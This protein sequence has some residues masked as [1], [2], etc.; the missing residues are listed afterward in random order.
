MAGLA[1]LDL[2]QPEDDQA[3]C[4]HYS[5]YRLLKLG[6]NR[7]ETI[8]YLKSRIGYTELPFGVKLGQPP[9][10]LAQRLRGLG[11]EVGEQGNAPVDRIKDLLWAGIPVILLINAAVEVRISTEPRLHYWV[12][13][14]YD[15]SY[16]YVLDPGS[17]DQFRITWYDLSILRYFKGKTAGLYSVDNVPGYGPTGKIA[18]RMLDLAPIDDAIYWTTVDTLERS[19]GANRG[20][21][22][23]FDRPLPSARVI[24][25]GVRPE[26]PSVISNPGAAAGVVSQLLVRKSSVPATLSANQHGLT[27]NWFQATTG[28]QGLQLEIYEDASGPGIGYVQGAWFTFDYA[29]SGGP[30]RQRWYT[31][32][33]R[34][35]ATGPPAELTLYAN[36]NGNF[37]APP[38][39]SAEVVGSVQLSFRDCNNGSFSYSFT[40]GS[41]RKGTLAITRLLKNV[42]CTVSGAPPSASSKEFAYSG[43]WYDASTSGQGIVVELN[44]AQGYAFVGWFTYAPA[45]TGQ[46]SGLAGQRWYTAQGKYTVGATTVPLTLHEVTGG[47]FDSPSPTPSFK[48]VGSATLS[49]VDCGHASF[50]YSF[51]GGSSSGMSR[52]ID[53]VRVGPT[54]KGCI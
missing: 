24:R 17:R 37:D 5:V 33:G 41:G 38:P 47:R 1:N 54:P 52:R 43:N 21:I 48:E 42:E 6:Y 4:G 11:Y 28:G 36:R 29:Q 2:L 25:A 3:S 23:Y 15:E 16:L 13:N 35:S 49:F 10:V 8:E 14:G 44:P 50:T 26:I 22:V 40:D 27:G 12:A 19:F 18:V 31:F 7:P 20:S 32:G 45:P 51:T 46:S 34:V 53:L 39:T 30:E 9:P